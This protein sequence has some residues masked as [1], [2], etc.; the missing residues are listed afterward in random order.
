MTAYLVSGFFDGTRIAVA[1]V[2]F[3]LI[4][5]TTRELHFAYGT[6]LA[7]CGYL[8]IFLVTSLALP[9]GVAAVITVLAATAA[10]VLIKGGLYRWLPNHLA[11][12]LFSFGLT[13]VL[14]N[15][16]LIVAGPDQQRLDVG[17]LTGTSRV[18]HDIIIQG[19]DFASLGI[20][21][22][23][24][25]GVYVLI[26]RR[27][28]GLAIRAVMRDPEMAEYVGVRKASV[29]IA[30]YAIGSGI[31]AG[32]ALIQVTRTG[33]D[34][35][36][37]FDIMLSAFV[38]TIL[39]AGQIYRLIGWAIALGVIQGLVS[40]Q[41]PSTWTQLVVY[42]A[43]LGYLVVRADPTVIRTGLRLRERLRSSSAASATS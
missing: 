14:Q 4:F 18:G 8:A 12:L 13:I 22:I 30:V 1:A 15:F 26:E 41:L 42:G 20:L 3:G 24:W 17:W 34:P 19:V 43:M 21:A 38:A 5:Y 36:T 28:L 9:L 10:G 31:A 40:W 37:G 7:A 32:S 2:G 27:K 16:L 39:G 33:V 29:G 6:V 11:V 25:L 23:V 35:I